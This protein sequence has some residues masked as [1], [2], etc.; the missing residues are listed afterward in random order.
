MLFDAPRGVTPPFPRLSIGGGSSWR[1]AQKAFRDLQ[2]GALPGE[3]L[4]CVLPREKRWLKLKVL[5]L[6]DDVCELDRTDDP[7]WCW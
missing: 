7:T 3:K 4:R 5:K 2:P 6:V 1:I